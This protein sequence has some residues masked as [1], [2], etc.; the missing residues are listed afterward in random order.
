MQEPNVSVKMLLNEFIESK[1]YSDIGRRGY[2]Y[3][4]QL[5]RGHTSRRK[6]VIY[7]ADSDSYGFSN[8]RL[9]SIYFQ[10]KFLK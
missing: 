6:R 5:Y 7:F 10:K 1:K 2:I 9:F 3:I 4:Y 8:C